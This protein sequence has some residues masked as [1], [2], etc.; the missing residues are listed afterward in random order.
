MM[1][2]MSGMGGKGRRQM[3]GNMMGTSNKMGR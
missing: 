2:M 3:M 1:K